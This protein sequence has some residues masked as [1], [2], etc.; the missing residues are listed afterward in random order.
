MYFLF[1]RNQI[2]STVNHHRYRRSQCAQFQFQWIF[3]KCIIEHVKPIHTNNN[4]NYNKTVLRKVEKKA[5]KRMRE[6]ASCDV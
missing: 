2:K 4:N 5:T 6:L 1:E 3:Q